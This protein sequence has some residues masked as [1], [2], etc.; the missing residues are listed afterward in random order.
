ML[1]GIFDHVCTYFHGGGNGISEADLEATSARLRRAFFFFQQPTL[2]LAAK[3]QELYEE[4]IGQAE[5]PRSVACAE[6]RFALWRAFYR[7]RTR[8]LP[9]ISLGENGQSHPG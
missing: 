7:T 3:Y 2:A 8:R 1:S 5:A 4:D 9:G 6:E